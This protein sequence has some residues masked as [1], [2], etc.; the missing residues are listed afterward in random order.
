MD[1]E[2]WF[3]YY[4]IYTS[5]NSWMIIQKCIVTQWISRLNQTTK[6]IFASCCQQTNISSQSGQL[7]RIHSYYHYGIA[8]RSAN[9]FFQIF[10]AKKLQECMCTFLGPVHTKPFSNVIIYRKKL[11]DSDWLRVVQFKCNSS[12]KSVTPVQ[13]INSGLWLTERQN[14]IF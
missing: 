9:Y 10:K 7:E 2:L 11:L 12:A 4:Q 3:G 8:V 5:I 6:E 13:I 1:C 14:E